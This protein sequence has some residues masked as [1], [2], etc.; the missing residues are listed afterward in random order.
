MVTW[1]LLENVKYFVVHRPPLILFVL[2][3]SSLGIAFFSLGVYIR[4]H[5][6]TN[7]DVPQ[8]WNTV[9][10]FLSKLEFCL[11]E[12]ESLRQTSTELLPDVVGRGSVRRRPDPDPSAHLTT[13]QPS[14]TV[15]YTPGT[16]DSVSLLVPMG[17]DLKEPLK[18]YSNITRFQAV[19]AGNLLGLEGSKAKEMINIMLTSPWPP[20]HYLSQVNSTNT[21]S[22]LSCITMSAAAQV[23]PQARYFPSCKLENLTDASLYQTTFAESSEKT[24]SQGRSSAQCYKA[25]YKSEPKFIIVLSKH[26]GCERD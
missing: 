20:E 24:A 8:A 26:V 16:P 12:T 19:V 10:Q 9:L 23:L 3:I 25:Q 14:A 17:F 18:R 6:I 11:T 2:S 4:S 5:E 7:P 13:Q 21:K 1:H 22:P 15:A